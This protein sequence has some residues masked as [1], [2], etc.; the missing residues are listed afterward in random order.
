MLSWLMAHIDACEHLFLVRQ[1][2]GAL[3]DRRP[4][5]ATLLGDGLTLPTIQEAAIIPL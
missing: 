5:G 3:H 1:V 4:I 2:I